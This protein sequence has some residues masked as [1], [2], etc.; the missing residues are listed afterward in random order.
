M[1]VGDKS[2]VTRVS[3]DDLRELYLRR[4]RVWPNGARAIPI[5]LPADNPALERFSVAV[6]GRSTQDLPVGEVDDT[7]RTLLVLDR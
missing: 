2:F 4:R 7:C 1:V 6:L 5:N 3:V